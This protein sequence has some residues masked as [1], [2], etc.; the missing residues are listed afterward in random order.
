MVQVEVDLDKCSLMG[1][2][3]FYEYVV[4]LAGFEV[5]PYKRFNCTK[6]FV[7]RTVQDYI[8]DG[9]KNRGAEDFEIGMIW[10][11]YG[12]KVDETLS[13][14]EVLIEPGFYE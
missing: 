7:S 9:Y 1:I 10:C 3:D 14:S 8:M 5:R 13:G 11:C 6:I 2:Q 12:P 4:K